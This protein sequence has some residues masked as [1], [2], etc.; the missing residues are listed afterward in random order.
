MTTY[1]N[2][3]MDALRIIEDTLDSI[4][5]RLERAKAIASARRRVNDALDLRLFRL[6]HDIHDDGV[7]VADIAAS[8]S[9]APRTV[10]Q[11]IARYRDRVGLP[12]RSR[13]HVDE[14]LAQAIEINAGYKG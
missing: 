4:P 10:S 2:D 6:M 9:M 3:V 11:W 12:P 5:D 1:D 14:L 13:S 8:V 7:R